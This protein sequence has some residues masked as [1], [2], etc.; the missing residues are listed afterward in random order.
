M[1][2]NMSRH[3]CILGPSRTPAERKRIGSQRAR[4]PRST[5]R[6]LRIMT[7]RQPSKPALPRDTAFPRHFLRIGV[8]DLPTTATAGSH[9]AEPMPYQWSCQI[10][11]ES[12]QVDQFGFLDTRGRD[13]RAELLETLLA[14][15]ERKGAILVPS[16]RETALLHGLQRRL[17]APSGALAAALT[18]LVEVDRYADRGDNPA[19]GR[20]VSVEHPAAWV[21]WPD[22][23]IDPS[24]GPSLDLRDD[25]AAQA[26]Y[27][28]LIDARTQNIRR[29]QLTRA[30][31]RYGD[32][33]LSE[34]VQTFAEHP[35]G[36]PAAAVSEPML[37]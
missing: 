35:G 20:T 16:A 36:D 17:A 2:Q 21:L 11:T 30:L 14:V 31:I 6:S 13:P 33:Q 12:G 19:I 5:D 7:A 10:E 23:A 26:A 28:E 37:N 18:R 25:L 15:I 34:L 9:H 27:L 1:R 22:N 29:R 8:L 32:L 3:G 4:H 24:L